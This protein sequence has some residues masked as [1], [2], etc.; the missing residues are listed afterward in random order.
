M[1]YDSYKTVVGGQTRDVK[2]VDSG[3]YLVS[4]DHLRSRLS[5]DVATSNALHKRSLPARKRIF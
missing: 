3:G 4:Y 5:T 1:L 2:T